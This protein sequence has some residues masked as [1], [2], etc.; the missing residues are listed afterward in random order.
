LN[1][2]K[3]TTDEVG[4]FKND[5]LDLS[6][7]W[8][9][10]DISSL[11]TIGF[12][13]THLIQII[14]QGKLSVGEVQ[15][16]INFYAFDLTRN[17]LKPK[18]ALNYFMGVVRRGLP[19]GPPDNY[20]S[21]ADEVRRK[22]LEFKSRQAATR[23]AEDQKLMEIEF[24]EWR[25]GLTPNDVLA[26]VPEFARRPGQVQESSLLSHFEKQIWPEIS[27]KMK[28]MTADREQIQR[29]IEQSLAGEGRG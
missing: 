16:S 25:R 3:T 21:P 9:Q 19:Y 15:D 23:Q 27:A 14:R 5:V 11:E 22:T 17:G 18:S 4:L 13:Q 10:I 6:P 12:T 20:E 26:I 1:N 8:Q 7:E 28:G 2:L 24:Q 29:E